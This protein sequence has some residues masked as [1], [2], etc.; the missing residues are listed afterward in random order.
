MAIMK[1]QIETGTPYMLSKDSANSKSNQKNVG[2]IKSSNLC[3]E[4]MEVSDADHTAVC[5]L[6][7]LAL[8]KFLGTNGV[9]DYQKLHNVVRT[10]TYNL[11]RV[12][13]HNY[14]PV[15]T[16]RRSNMKLRPIGI[17][18]QG[19]ADVFMMLRIPFDSLEARDVNKN[20][21]ETIY[22]AALEQSCEMAETEGA[23]EGFDGS[24]AHMGILQ[25]DMWNV[26]PSGRFDWNALK[27][28]IKIHGLRNSLLVAPM[29]TATTA[30]ILGNNEAFEP[31]TTNI[32]LRRTLAG[33]FVVVNRHLVNEL[34]AIGL[35]SPEMKNKII[36]N[37]G[38]V[39]GIDEIPADIQAIYKTAW[40]LSQ[41]SIIDQ[42]ADRGAF[43]DQSQSMNLFVEAPSVGKLSSMHMYSWKMGLKT[44]S[45]YVRTRAKA[46]AQQVTVEPDVC[47][48]CSA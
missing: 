4:I 24:P 10:L 15:E 6:G 7:S 9:F 39:Q 1:S 32:Y 2:V 43:I 38:S 16:A 34:S 12:I 22:H 41:K 17:G 36:R 46:R 20:I 35:W 13:D 23:Y 48:T 37:D 28:R 19:L 31:Y 47:E 33:E 18:V 25:F 27:E 11:N 8:P 14:Y 30:Q 5:N 45:Y 42:A 3:T 21:F 40:E 44:L 26:I 29:P